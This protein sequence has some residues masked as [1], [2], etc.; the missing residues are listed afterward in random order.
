[1]E[2][3]DDYF[4]DI[5]DGNESDILIDFDEDNSDVDEVEFDDENILDID[6][7]AYTLHEET[8]ETL[9]SNS[10]RSGRGFPVKF[11]KLKQNG[12]G[13]EIPSLTQ[14]ILT[15]PKDL[16]M[17][18][19]GATI[20]QIVTFT[21][22]KIS[23][24]N[25]STTTKT[26]KQVDQNE[27]LHYF[28]I[29]ILISLIKGPHVTFRDFY[30]D[31]REKAAYIFRSCKDYTVDQLH[32]FPYYRYLEINRF[33]NQIPDMEY[34]DKKQW[35]KS[36]AQA[37]QPAGGYFETVYNPNNPTVACQVQ[38]LTHLRALEKNFNERSKRFCLPDADDG[39]AIDEILVINSYATYKM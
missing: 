32:I 23:N 38:N 25:S 36:A 17:L 26:V 7:L 39:L 37:Y 19:F 6:H 8:P 28:G 14:E 30:G 20:L 9:E 33:L 31:L 34:V 11:D 24:Y 27:I 18:M 22:C 21:N 3:E 10:T 1:M 5:S 35:K 29:K 16:F 13:V 4:F 12:I 2:D 15:K